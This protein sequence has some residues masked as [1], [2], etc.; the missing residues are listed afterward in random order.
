MRCAAG[1]P[2]ADKPSA[3]NALTEATR[4]SHLITFSFSFSG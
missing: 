3:K 4:W 2:D 1:P